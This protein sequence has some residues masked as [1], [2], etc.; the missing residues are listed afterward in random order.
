MR[1]AIDV[2]STNVSKT[3]ETPVDFKKLVPETAMH[4]NQKNKLFIANVKHF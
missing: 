2:L 3:F 1:K 4:S